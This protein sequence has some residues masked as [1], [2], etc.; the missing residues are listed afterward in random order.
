MKRGP[1]KEGEAAI[2]CITYNKKVE[3]PKN[4]RCFGEGRGGGLGRVRIS[5]LRDH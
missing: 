2:H 3:D 4:S 1:G 5:I